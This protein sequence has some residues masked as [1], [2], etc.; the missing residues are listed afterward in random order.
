VKTHAPEHAA[1]RPQ[2]EQRRAHIEHELGAIAASVTGDDDVARALRYAL[3]APGKRLRPVLCIAAIEALRGTYEHAHVRAATAIEL[4]HT[5]SLVHDDL[6]CMDDDDLRRGRATAHRVFG[7]AAA[8]AAGFALIPLA[9][10][11]VAAACAEL[12]LE[13]RVTANALRELC[14]GAGAAGMVGGQMLDLEAEGQPLDLARLRRV[15]AMKTGALFAAAARMGAVIAGADDGIVDAFGRYGSSLGLAFQ[16]RDDV[17][18]VTTDASTL[19]KTP[20]KDEASS[21]ATFAALLGVDR[22]DFVA[23]SE[24]AAAVD[25]LAAAGISSDLLAGLAR[26]AAYRGQ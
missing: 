5:Y 21:K 1:L 17:L 7:T 9:A 24:A 12:Q 20:G 23:Q 18:D 3:D 10:R 8:M 16:I 19:G 15:H 2:L 13:P 4:V 6:P 25:S 11:T 26:F 22:A 14:A